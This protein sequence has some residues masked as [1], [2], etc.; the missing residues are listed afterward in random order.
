MSS[1]LDGTVLSFAQQ[2][3]W[4]LD[5]LIP[6]SP[7][8][9]ASRA[10]RLTGSLDA[11]ALARAVDHVVARHP[12][13]RSRIAVRNG[14]P[15][16]VIDPPGT[17]VLRVDDLSGTPDA[18]QRARQLLGE[19]CRVPMD[20][21][22]GPLFRAGLV[23][24]GAGLSLFYFTA[25]HVVFDGISRL[26]VERDIAAAYRAFT[27]GARLEEP[28]IRTSYVDYAARQR[29]T[30]TGPA[31]AEELDYWRDRLGG[32]ASELA[33][34]TA[35]P[36]P[37][38]P[39]LRGDQVNF[40][41][42]ATVDE[43]LRDIADTCRTSPFFVALA[44]YQALLGFHA[45]ATDVSV[46]VP[47]AGR[48][49]PE[50]DDLDDVVG[51]FVNTV[52]LRTDLAG[53][54]A[55]TSVVRQVRGHTLDAMDHQDV[56]FELL[57]EHLD[58]SHDPAR[59]PLFQHWF[60]FSDAGSPLSAGL[61]LPGIGCDS[62]E[63][64]D[65]TSRFDL[66]LQ[67]RV[68]GGDIAGELT[69]STD[70]FD[71]AA[72]IRFAEQYRAVLAA[73]VA[74]PDAPL[75]TLVRLPEADQ[76]AVLE[77]GEGPRPDDDPTL[78]LPAGFDRIATAHPDAVAVTAEGTALTYRELRAHGDA[79]A[80]RLAALGIGPDD[81][82]AVH[83]RRD[84]DLVPALVGVVKAGA[85][86]LPIDATVPAARVAALLA[87]SGA[88]AV[89]T[90]EDL[91]GNLPESAPPVL[92][93]DTP[94]KAGTDGPI[95]YPPVDALCY[96]IYTSGS[97]GVPKGVAVPHRAFGNLIR[98][99]LRRYR[100]GPD[101]RVGQLASIS[102][103]AAAWEIWPALL[104][105]AR[106]DLYPDELVRTPEELGAA[107]AARG[108]TTTFAPT[109]VAEQL[110]RSP[111]RLTT[112]LTG[113]DVFRPRPVDDPGTAVV[114]HYGPTEN[115]VV[116]TA[117]DPLRSPWSELSVG[118]PID[119]VR[120]YVLDDA[121]RLVPPGTVGQLH[122]G[123]AGL[124]RGYLGRPGPTAEAFLPDPFADRPG[125]RMYRTGDL[126][127]WRPDGALDFV[128]RADQ[129]IKVRGVRIE[130]A[131]IEAVLLNHPMVR[132]V[133]VTAAAAGTAERMLVAHVVPADPQPSTSDLRRHAR[134]WLAEHLV[135]A[136]FVFLT[137]LPYG[138]TGKVDRNR[139]PAPD[140]GQP[141]FVAP[142]TDAERTVAGLWRDVLGVA[143]VGAQDDF[144]ALGGTSMSA[145]RLTVRLRES[146]GIDFELREIFE[147]RT[148][149]DIGA[150][151]QARL[152][153]AIAAMS[154]EEIASALGGTAT[155]G[156]ER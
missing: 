152:L 90:T 22:R 102:F 70:L 54:P 27:T 145:A 99:H 97:T 118:R 68:D 66:E 53:D 141:R 143:R 92:T 135:P 36:R 2:R 32:A 83:L 5:Q 151:V 73:V 39:T 91:R 79:L 15:H 45:A 55:F 71:R 64:L 116:A 84:R 125:A 20:L 121:L 4:L 140:L 101:S 76:R 8:Y 100:L 17:P 89:V 19:R 7:A 25:H 81:V 77:L 153:A 127:R 128:G 59:N 56:P 144:F 113:G 93:V 155:E 72:V 150:V 154:D 107:F 85:A 104:S 74:D 138:T 132:D 110:I 43:G 103:D 112:L 142:S 149:A 6:G 37:P 114:N 51:F 13:L 1:T 115:A 67:L 65:G 48:T 33:L 52:V 58:P 40:R 47:F 98:W 96:L 50:L 31:L 42:E 21:A 148:V 10:Y 122:L 41:I 86:Y 16:P 95:A 156:S 137:E 124:A 11:H 29:A 78:T 57:V 26:I 28:E 111:L 134:Q 38:V 106:L 123:G 23:R 109:A 80:G 61:S 88:R 126:V 69:Y 82:V 24:V 147:H 34:P 62:L 136:V 131:E 94:T 139:L 130:P 105:G 108:T 12:M 9:L 117:T 119:G 30:L 63:L 146:F 18:E 44:A 120:A 87:D 3:L 46:G 60:D 35:R 75:S 49:D 14:Q 129:Q 133:V